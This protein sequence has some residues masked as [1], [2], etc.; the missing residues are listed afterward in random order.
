MH[1]AFAKQSNEE[2]C[3]L[4]MPHIRIQPVCHQAIFPSRLVN[5]APPLNKE[6]YSGKCDPVAKQH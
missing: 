3:V 5:L 1:H 2:P 6:P 4:G